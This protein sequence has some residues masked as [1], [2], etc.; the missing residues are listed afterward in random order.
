MKCDNTT[1]FTSKLYRATTSKVFS[2]QNTI[3]SNFNFW[4]Q[5]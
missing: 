1:E 3:Y 4:E 2:E 5:P